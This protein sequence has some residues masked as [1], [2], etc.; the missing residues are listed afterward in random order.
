MSCYV[1]KDEDPTHNRSCSSIRRNLD[2]HDLLPEH[3][4]SHASPCIVQMAS[5]HDAGALAHRPSIPWRFFSS[6][7]II[8]FFFFFIFTSIFLFL[9]ILF[10][11][12][13]INLF[14]FSTLGWVGVS[15]LRSS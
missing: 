15:S 6:F 12:H 14:L 5:P 13:F 7:I 1:G 8:I 3:H 11:F 2:V 10:L 4:P 9:I